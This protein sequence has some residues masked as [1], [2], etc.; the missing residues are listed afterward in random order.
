MARSYPWNILC[1]YAD[2]FTVT[3]CNPGSHECYAGLYLLAMIP[4]ALP[5][6]QLIPSPNYCLILKSVMFVIGTSLYLSL[7]P[8]YIINKNALPSVMNYHPERLSGLHPLLRP[9]VA[10]AGLRFI[11][12]PKMVL[13]SESSFLHLDSAG[14]QDSSLDLI[15]EMLAL[16]HLASCKTSTI[17]LSHTS[18]PVFVNPSVP[19]ASQLPDSSAHGEMGFDFLSRPSVKA[20]MSVTE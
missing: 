2:T 18:S 8:H 15:F 13:N 16:E 3:G 10:Q 11:I 9:H 1:L 20:H 17:H 14:I 5:V 6:S 7:A 12:Q 4:G 19:R